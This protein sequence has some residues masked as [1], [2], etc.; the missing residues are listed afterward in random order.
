M[1]SVSVS[2]L[3]IF[4]AA[5][6]VAV[7]VATTLTV[8]VESMSVSLDERGDSVAQDIET[9]I[10]IISDA[11]SPDSIYSTDDGTDEITLLVKN[12][13]NRP[14]HTDS[15]DIDVLI[16]GAYQ[17]EVDIEVIGNE[18]STAWREGDVVRITVSEPLDD[19]EHRA[20]V[21]VRSS[22]DILRFHVE[23]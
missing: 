15:G 2:H 4:I 23:S 12:T 10:D 19:G 21:R 6:T 5:L 13:G 14:I 17:A 18:G 16:N 1:A 11:G 8:N 3:V 20:T 9:E 7:G 22:E